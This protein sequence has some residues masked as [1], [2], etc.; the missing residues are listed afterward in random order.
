[1]WD[2]SPELNKEY[3]KNNSNSKNKNIDKLKGENR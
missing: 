3:I 2:I 1:M